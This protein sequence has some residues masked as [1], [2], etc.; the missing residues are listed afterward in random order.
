QYDYAGDYIS[1]FGFLVERAEGAQDVGQF[2]TIEKIFS[3]RGAAMIM[4]KDVFNE[5]GGFDEDYGYYWE[6]PDIAWRIWLHGYEVYFLPSVTVYHAFGTDEKQIEYYLDNDIIFKGCRNAITTMIKNF[7]AKNLFFRFP[8]HILFWLVLSV[9]IFIK[10]EFSKS[11]A[12]WRGVFWNLFHIYKTCSKRARI[13]SSRTRTDDELFH[14]VGSVK[15]MK[16]YL[17][18]AISFVIGKPFDL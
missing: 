11:Y 4:R 7:E 5:V 15:P 18:K 17:S 12:I 13:Q 1:S 10:G 9:P 3:V 8:I 14:L 16:Y 2:D 6:E